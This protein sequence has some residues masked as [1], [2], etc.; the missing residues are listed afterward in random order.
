GRAPAVVERFASSAGPAV[1]A[2]AARAGGSGSTGAIAAGGAVS[3]NP[4][5]EDVGT[6]GVVAGFELVG[7][8]GPLSGSEPLPAGSDG[9]TGCG[10][11]GKLTG[12]AG[13][14]PGGSDC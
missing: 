3:G 12:A 14:S 10:P 6:A 2:S 7:S 4:C 5:A 8:E 9:L 13:T 11:P 1:A